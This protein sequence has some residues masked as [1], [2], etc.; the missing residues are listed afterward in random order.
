MKCKNKIMVSIVTMLI[1]LLILP[2][3]FVKLSKPDVVMGIMMIFFFIVNP[4]IT[5]VINLM[6]G[7]DV[8][9]TWWM[10]ILF[11]GVFL[12]SYWI[13]LKEIILDLI[14][15]A[16]IYLIIGLIF[17]FVSLFVSKKIK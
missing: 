9:K 2:L 7:M 17:M 1:V 8:K 16:L 12:L 13:I 3:V 4:L 14:V 15:Y 6:V 11:S 10:P 5:A